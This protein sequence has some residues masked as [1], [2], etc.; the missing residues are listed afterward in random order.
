MGK[1]IITSLNF[2]LKVWALSY[3]YRKWIV[4]SSAY[5]YG[6]LSVYNAYHTLLD[7]GDRCY[8]DETL[9]WMSEVTPGNI[10]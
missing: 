6:D 3:L 4:L 8:R 1:L 7:V 2:L 10:V 5:Q 9:E